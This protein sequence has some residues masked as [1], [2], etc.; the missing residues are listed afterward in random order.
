LIGGGKD[1][2]VQEIGGVRIFR[3]RNESNLAVR[4]K[5]EPFL[6]AAFGPGKYTDFDVLQAIL[7]RQVD[8]FGEQFDALIP[9]LASLDFLGFILWQYDESGKLEDLFKADK[10]KGQAFDAWSGLGPTYRR[11]LKYIAE[12]VTMLVPD[13]MVETMPSVDVLD[14]AF[15]CAEELIDYC[16]VS[17]QTNLFK[18]GTVVEIQPEGQK[19]Y[20]DHDILDPRITKFQQRIYTDAAVRKNFFDQPDYESD[21]DTHAKDLDAP[22]INLIGASL[23]EC[24]QVLRLTRDGCPPAPNNPYKTKFVLRSEVVKNL[25]AHFNKTEITVDRILQGFS[26]TKKDLKSRSRDGEDI[27]NPQSHHRAYRRGMFV[28]PHALGEH[29]VFS[30]RMFYECWNIMQSEICYGQFPKEWE[31]KSVRTALGHVVRKR[32][33]W[34]EEQVK[35]NLARLSINGVSSRTSIGTGRYA[36]A[37]PGEFDFLGWSLADSALILFEDKMLQHGSEPRL[38]KNQVNAFVTGDKDEEAFVSKIKRKAEWVRSNFVEVCN[39]LRSEGIGAEVLP[40]RLLSGFLSFTPL[41][42]S[43]FVDD[44]PCASVSEFVRDYQVTGNWPYENGTFELSI[45]AP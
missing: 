34:F 1:M 2:L 39:A 13:D 33:E 41:A 35:K 25:A 15:I 10:L 38:W 19:T 23:G 12:R 18:T 28:L 20:I 30:D 43:Y 37:L 17:D 14:E 5:A 24:L 21:F 26:L 31:S 16:I 44:F 11:A 45:N 4:K 29:L 32:G 40:T 22:L 3:P 8:F 42:A 27:W 36:M 7:H 6:R 9:K